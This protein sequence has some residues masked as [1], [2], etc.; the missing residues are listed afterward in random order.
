MNVATRSRAKDTEATPAQTSPGTGATASP[1]VPADD[2]SEPA[3]GDCRSQKNDVPNEDENISIPTQNI[4]HFKE[5][6]VNT[7]RLLKVFSDQEKEMAKAKAELAK[8]NEEAKRMHTSYQSLQRDVD[9]RVRELAKANAETENARSLLVLREAELSRVRGQREDLEARISELSNA[10]PAVEQAV[11]P[12]SPNLVLV[13]DID[14]LKKELESKEGSLKSLRI[15]RDAIRSSTK[16]EIMSIQARY[17][18]EQKELIERQEKEM[19]EHRASLA[20]KETEQEQE[21]E[22]LMQLDMDLTMRETQM[23]DQ[24]A[25][26]KAS[27]DEITK[28]HH[29]AQQTIKRLEEQAKS[30]TADFRSEIG[31]LQREL[32]KSEKQNGDLSAALKRAQDGARAAKDSARAKP[33]QRPRSTATAAEAVQAAT[34]DVASM[35]PEEL[36]KEVGSLR[37]DSVHQEETIRRYRVM[38]EELERKQNPEGPRPR[39]RV[40]TLEKEVEKLKADV[41]EREKQINALKSV[42]NL[43]SSGSESGIGENDVS[44]TATQAVARIAQLDLKIIEM[45]ATIK[46]RNQTI[47]TLETEVKEA[48]ESASERPMRLRHAHQSSPTNTPGSTRSAAGVGVSGGRRGLRSVMSSNEQCEQHYTEITS[49]RGRVDRLKQEKVALQELVTEQQVKIRQLRTGQPGFATQAT[50]VPVSTPGFTVQA[51]PLSASTPTPAQRKRTQLAPATEYL[52]SPNAVA[53]KRARYASAV[54]G[55]ASPEPEGH[56]PV[57]VI[58]QPKKAASS[59]AKR[60]QTA[61]TAAVLHSVKTAEKLQPHEIKDVLT[62]RR[63]LDTTRAKRCFGLVVNSPLELQGVLARM[64]ETVPS[65]DAARF[66]ELLIVQIHADANRA[67]SPVSVLPC[68]TPLETPEEKF[69]EGSQAASKLKLLADGIRPGLYKH[70]AMLVMSIWTIVLKS[71]QFS[72]FSELMYK[73]SQGIVLRSS[74]SAAATCSLARIFVT[75]SLLAADIQRVRVMLCDMLMD[76]VDSPHALPVLAN[77]LAIWPDVLQMPSTSVSDTTENVTEQAYELMIRVFQAIAAGIHDLYKEEKG[78]EEADKLYSVM[79]AQCGWRLPGHAEFADTLLVEV[80]N[81]LNGLDHDSRGY[82]VVM[83]AFNLLAPYMI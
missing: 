45:E 60:T 12:K 46:E 7:S 83:A 27:I 16:A 29:S 43:A 31:K 30:R 72:F 59:R 8:H 71:E 14:R 61:S 82:P 58:N 77:S 15:S 66:A 36:R 76:A 6:V 53:S 11:P 17:A 26:L 48:R 23:E 5:Q 25:E 13:E 70:E 80:K 10:V 3:D 18:R 40:H 39:G 56:G 74:A 19:S 64:D 75:L 69:R 1:V 68:S 44:N 81:T 22:R 28:N 57:V 37:V 50:P 65:I 9:A 67:S 20:G 51:T 73:L 52:N 47:Q 63:I 38:L 24:V 79:V 49:L 41:D 34:E 78:P 4:R 21:Q 33:K 55:S 32:K 2:P 54:A 42:L 62:N 35:S